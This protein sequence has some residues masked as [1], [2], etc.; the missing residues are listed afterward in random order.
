MVSSWLFHLLYE[1]LT[2]ITSDTQ[3]W[4]K[5]KVV[6]TVDQNQEVCVTEEQ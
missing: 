2:Y 1:G 5:A 3:I 6:E 4:N